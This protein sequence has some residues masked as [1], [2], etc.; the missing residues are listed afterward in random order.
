M[1]AGIALGVLIFSCNGSRTEISDQLLV[2]SPVTIEPSSTSEPVNPTVVSSAQ[3]PLPDRSII[4]ID[5]LLVPACRNDPFAG[6][7]VGFGTV[8]RAPESLQTFSSDSGDPLPEKMAALAPVIRWA[9]HFTEISDTGWGRARSESDF[10]SIIFDESRRVWLA[11]NAIALAVPIINQTDPGLLA[12][13]KGLLADRQVWLA[14]RLEVLRNNP[15]SIRNTD[16]Y[17]GKTSVGLRKLIW[18]LDA[19][20]HEAGIEDVLIPVPFTVLNPLLEISIDMPAEWMLIRNRVDIVLVAPPDQHVEGVRGMGVPGWNFGTALQVRRMRHEDPWTL[21]DT[22]GLMDSLLVKFGERVSDKN[23]EVGGAETVIRAY[24]SSD[25]AWIT[26]AAATV[27][28]S[29]TYLF[30]LG[31]PIE[32]RISCEI[33]LREIVSDAQFTHE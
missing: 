9:N 14:D 26:I 16:S 3:T 22:A 20:S 24:E 4:D 23:D 31:C 10:A 33:L 30:T 1:I 6:T 21:S 29:H 7:A 19:L 11:C 13:A 25:D 5:D 12:S 18:D 28:N 8:P 17:R 15:S 2:S 32:S 27:N